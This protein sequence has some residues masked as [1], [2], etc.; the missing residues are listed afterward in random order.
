MPESNSGLF[1]LIYRSKRS[2]T[3]SDGDIVDGIVLPANRKNRSFDVTGC[4]WFD[5]Q[6]FVQVLEGP[7]DAVLAV[8]GAIA[9]DAR[10]SELRVLRQ[11]AIASRSFE[12]WG[13][14][15]L[16]GQSDPSIASIASRYSSEEASP[17]MFARVRRWMRGMLEPAPE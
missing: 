14:R 5:S 8:Y 1:E 13:M 15:S 7:Q 11:G 6:Q 16:S 9:R 3:L 17:D 4:L 12:R 10:H 2:T